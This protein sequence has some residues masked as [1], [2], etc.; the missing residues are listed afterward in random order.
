MKVAIIV[1]RLNVKGGTQRQALELGLALTQ[2]KHSVKFY[3][4]KYDP[5]NC[6]EEF[7]NISVTSLDDE[8]NP[9]AS[10]LSKVS[11]LSFFI[12]L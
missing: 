7:K 11:Y 6:Y 4:F 5:S 1:R 9:K 8:S 12:S 3:T 10:F 2:Q